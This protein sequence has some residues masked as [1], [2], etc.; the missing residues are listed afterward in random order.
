M[1][2]K[3]TIINKTM[4]ILKIAI[5]IMGN[6]TPEH[7]CSTDHTKLISYAQI[8]KIKITNFIR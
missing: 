5:D 3:Y 2:F 8:N 7:N 4:N 6:I 1:F